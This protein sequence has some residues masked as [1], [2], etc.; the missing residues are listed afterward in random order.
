MGVLLLHRQS[1]ALAVMVQIGLINATMEYSDEDISKGLQNF[2]VCIEM[3]VAA[4]AHR[5]VFE[6]QDFVGEIDDTVL[7]RESAVASASKSAS[8]ASSIPANEKRA[9]SRLKFWK[10][11][12]Y[13]RLESEDLEVDE[14]KEDGNGT[15][16]PGEIGCLQEDDEEARSGEGAENPNVGDQEQIKRTKKPFFR[17]F[18]E[19]SFP[20]DVVSDIGRHVSRSHRDEMRREAGLQWGPA[21]H[22]SGRN[23]RIEP[24]G[25][26]DISAAAEVTRTAREHESKSHTSAVFS[27]YQQQPRETTNYNY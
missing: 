2:L 20:G 6:Y 23:V 8:I 5:W 4:I 10:K 1:I 3:F 16:A 14:T 24:R 11:N 17:A 7:T 27:D 26:H 25:V 13:Q 9:K 22:F 15:A 21:S 18:I 19:S 12:E